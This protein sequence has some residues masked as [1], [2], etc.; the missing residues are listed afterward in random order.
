VATETGTDWLIDKPASPKL[1]PLIGKIDVG[2]FLQ[3]PPLDLSR[4]VPAFLRI[5]EKAL[6][7]GSRANGVGDSVTIQVHE[8]DLG[9]LQIET[10]RL[11]I[12]LKG[13]AV[14]KAGK[15]EGKIAGECLSRDEQVG[16][17][18][19]VSV[20]HLDARVCQMKTC[21]RFSHLP[22]QVKFAV[23]QVAPVT[24][25]AIHLQDIRRPFAEKIH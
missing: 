20:N 15:P 9:V 11:A 5:V 1:E 3:R 10:R 23:P 12:A 25:R 8:F 22:S 19:T 18:V 6:Q 21:W 24:N 4:I 2:K 17:P 13:A 7:P 16:A 14:P